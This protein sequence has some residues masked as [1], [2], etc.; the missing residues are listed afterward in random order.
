MR[1]VAET[2][3]GPIVSQCAGDHMA[4]YDVARAEAAA[5]DDGEPFTHALQ[6]CRSADVCAGYWSKG[7]FETHDADGVT[8]EI[9]FCAQGLAQVRLEHSLFAEAGI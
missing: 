6:L 5:A 7:H 3:H 1:Q 4:A 8:M 2:V 9:A